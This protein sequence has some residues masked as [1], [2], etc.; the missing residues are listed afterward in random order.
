MGPEPTSL[1][2]KIEK[3]DLRKLRELREEARSKRD[4]GDRIRFNNFIESERVKVK[5]LIPF[6]PKKLE[7]AARK[8]HSNCELLIVQVG[9]DI[10]NEELTQHPVYGELI[11]YLETQGLTNV[12]TGFYTPEHSGVRL[13]V[14]LP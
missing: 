7:E 6:L 4:L 1:Q 13:Y 5:A 11:R 10:T 14:T 8:G 3:I 9:E 2:E 12:H